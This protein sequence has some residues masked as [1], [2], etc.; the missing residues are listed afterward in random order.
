M[1]KVKINVTSL[2]IRINESD[3]TRCCFD[4]LANGLKLT[5]GLTF[6]ELIEYLVTIYR[7]K[8]FGFGYTEDYPHI[9]INDIGV[10]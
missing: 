10:V 9:T 6:G 1:G 2:T 5:D 8:I 7:D 3:K 4:V